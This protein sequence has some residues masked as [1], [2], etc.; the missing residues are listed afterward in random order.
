MGSKENKRKKELKRKQKAKRLRAKK[1]KKRQ[2][3][4]QQESEIIELESRPVRSSKATSSPNSQSFNL[5]AFKGDE[6]PDN[7]AEPESPRKKRAGFDKS[8]WGIKD[9]QA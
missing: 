7:A 5:S 8:A 9:E 1:Q 3:E 4:K 2:A 6:A